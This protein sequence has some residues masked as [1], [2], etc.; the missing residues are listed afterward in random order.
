MNPSDQP[1]LPP[2]PANGHKGTFGTVSVFGGCAAGTTRMLGA[3]ALAALAALRSGCGLAR[4]L[5]P[6]PLIEHLLTLAPVATGIALGVRENGEIEGHLAAAEVDRQSSLSE[7]MVV[8]PGL[9]SSPG[10]RALVLRAIQKEATPMVLDADALN[11]MAEIV[12]IARDFHAH[13]ILTPHP[14]EFRR[15]ARS[16][17]ISHDPVAETSRP[18]AAEELARRIGAI[19]VL[20]GAHTVVS[21]G[22]QCW[23][24]PHAN[25]ALATG[26]SGDVLSGIL[27]GLI[28]QQA[29][30]GRLNLFE[31]ARAGVLVHARA[32]DAWSSRSDS[33]GG[34]LATDLLE[35]IPHACEELRKP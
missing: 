31:I 26:G 18:Q 29:S 28:A 5:A 32:A 4:I 11:A 23:V 1:R 17:N 33:T 25:P 22:L 13:A 16:L 24:C 9:G 21:D 10:V 34:M 19:V 2:R 8:G 30:T 12:D 14:G 20:K 27:G 6:A 7:C 3:P 15:L 35:L